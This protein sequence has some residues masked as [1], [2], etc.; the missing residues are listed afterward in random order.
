MS[1]WWEEKMAIAPSNM[2]KDWRNFL[3]FCHLSRR[4]NIIGRSEGNFE[5]AFGREGRLF[6]WDTAF[7]DGDLAFGC[8]EKSGYGPVNTRRRRAVV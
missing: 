6:E 8:E 3:R 4:S 5:Q 2:P 7:I 1:L